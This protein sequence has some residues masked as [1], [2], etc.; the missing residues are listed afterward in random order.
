[1]TNEVQKAIITGASN[2]IGRFLTEKLL[3][4]GIQV[5]AVT[6]SGNIENF[7][8]PNLTVVKGD[9]SDEGSINQAIEQIG[10]IASQVDYLINNAGVGPDLGDEI[11]T[12]EHLNTSFAVNTTGTVLFTEGVLKYLKNDAHVVFL[13]TAMALIRNAGPNG[14]AYRMSKA[15]I[16]MYAVILAQR[17]AE[18]NIRVTPL[19]PGWVQTRMGGENA[20]VT[21]EQSVTGIYKAL[22]E[23]T[24]SG[25]FW[26]IEVGGL[27]EY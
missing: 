11:P 23:N 13:S 20:P 8:H 10:Q 16:N 19:H 1:M 26:N 27:E 14:P 4:E 22:T 21:V 25:K 12:A 7:T 24:E 3:N 15:A 18:R 6:R 17:L 9:I 2:G 5:I